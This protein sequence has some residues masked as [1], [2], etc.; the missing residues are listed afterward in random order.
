M[1]LASLKN[2][3][4]PVRYLMYSIACTLF[5]A[6]IHR[7]IDLLCCHKSPSRTRHQG[8]GY[9]FRDHFNFRSLRRQVE[10]TKNCNGTAAGETYAR[11]RRCLHAPNYNIF[12][13][14][15]RY[16]P[17][18]TNDVC[19]WAFNLNP[20]QNSCVRVKL[21]RGGWEKESHNAWPNRPRASIGPPT[22]IFFLLSC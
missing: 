16:L 21:L 5:V 11:L 12:S 9:G 22:G 7:I 6:K 20:F 17:V 19:V 4:A 3:V 13:N 8:Y 10:S 14:N 15:N 18:N 1:A 2:L